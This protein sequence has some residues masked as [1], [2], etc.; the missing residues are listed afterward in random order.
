M[1]C[2]FIARTN[3]SNIESN[4][5]VDIIIIFDLSYY[6][7]IYQ[8]LL[9][10][11]SKQCCAM[12]SLLFLQRITCTSPVPSSTLICTCLIFPRKFLTEPTSLTMLS[13]RP[14]FKTNLF[15]SHTAERII[16]AM[17]GIRVCSPLFE[18]PF[19]TIMLNGFLSSIKGLSLMNQLPFQSFC[20]GL[21][22]TNNAAKPNCAVPIGDNC[23]LYEGRSS[24]ELI[25]I[26]IKE[27]QLS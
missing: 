9:H 13:G 14:S 27:T 5:F 10:S 24:G 19:A 6:T 3:W 16:F 12:H 21:G 1:R 18:T 26:K 4:Y 2:D 20:F 17:T 22:V 23:S 8:L 25:V 11:S 7:N 15:E